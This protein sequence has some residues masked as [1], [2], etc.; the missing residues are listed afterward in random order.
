MAR[1]TKLCEFCE[2]DYFESQSVGKSEVCVEFYPDNGTFS[3][4]GFLTPEDEDTTEIQID[5]NFE[6]CPIC[7]RKIGW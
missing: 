7:G 5:Y 4:F 6:Y 3:I 2:T 1:R